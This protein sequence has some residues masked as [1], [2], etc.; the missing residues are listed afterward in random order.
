MVG[1]IQPLP[2]GCAAQ[3]ETGLHD[4]LGV[5]IPGW[6]IGYQTLSIAETS[7]LRRS[8]LLLL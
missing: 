4:T 2:V 5:V 1:D 7:V 3:H 6:P 8:L